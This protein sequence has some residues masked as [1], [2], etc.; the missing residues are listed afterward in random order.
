MFASTNLITH[1][2]LYSSSSLLNESLLYDK[3]WGPSQRVVTLF[4][5]LF[6]VRFF[7]GLLFSLFDSKNLCP[8]NPRG[9]YKIVGC[10]G[11]ESGGDDN[12]D[13]HDADDGND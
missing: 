2:S 3:L 1:E 13:D 12:H 6:M 7:L 10:D 5:I 8:G 4:Y 11:R 9:R